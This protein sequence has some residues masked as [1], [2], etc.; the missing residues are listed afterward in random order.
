MVNRARL[1]VTVSETTKQDVIKLLNCPAEKIKVIY[2]GY[3][4]SMYY[5]TAER[6]EQVYKMYGVRNYLLAVG[7]TYPH[8]NFETL[9]KAYKETSSAFRQSHPLAIAGGMKNYV[10]RLKDLVKELQL[11]KHVHFLGYVPKPLMPAMY[12]EAF[13][14]IFPSLYEGFGFPLLEAMACGCPVIASNCSSI[15]EVC[16]EAALYFDPLDTTS[17]CNTMEKLSVDDMLRRDLITKGIQ[18]AGQ[19]S[20]EQ[21]ALAYKQIIDNQIPK[22]KF[23]THV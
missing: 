20:W 18:R 19:F 10:D 7:P 21:T 13:A 3:D 8:K 2:N 23:Y 12:R 17:I 9:L 1:I 16:D 22:K 6:G 14:L 11:N 4:Q 15:P 5:Q